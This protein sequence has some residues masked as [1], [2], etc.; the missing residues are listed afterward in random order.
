MQEEIWLLRYDPRVRKHLAKLQD[1]AVIRRIQEAAERLRE[2]PYSGKQPKGY[3]A[4][5]SKR[6]GKL[7]VGSTGSSAFSVK[8]NTRCSW[9]L[10]VPEKKSTISRSE[11]AYESLTDIDREAILRRGILFPTDNPQD[12]LYGDE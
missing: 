9:L 6:I 5:R 2:N 12:L 10:L 8:R 4:L 7:R 11:A 1:K 3:P